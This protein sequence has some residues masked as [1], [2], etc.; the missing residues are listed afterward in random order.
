MIHH[1][2][3][4]GMFLLQRHLLGK[5]ILELRLSFNR[6]VLNVFVDMDVLLPREVVADCVRLVYN[7]ILLLQRVLSISLRQM[8]KHG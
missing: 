6:L 1:W 3:H 4:L 8:L 5:L 2:V 7:Y